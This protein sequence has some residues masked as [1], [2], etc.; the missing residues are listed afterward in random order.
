MQQV[1]K[2]STLV[3]YTLNPIHNSTIEN[4]IVPIYTLASTFHSFTILCKMLK[5]LCKIENLVVWCLLNKESKGGVKKILVRQ[6]IFLQLLP[7]LDKITVSI[8]IC[9][10][11]L[12]EKDISTVVTGLKLS[13]NIFYVKNE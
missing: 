5:L 6:M 13:P 1:Q 2:L 11:K 9:Q 10:Q 7:I 8:Y 4:A 12:I 3:I